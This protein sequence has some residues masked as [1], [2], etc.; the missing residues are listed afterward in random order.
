M[1][2]RIAERHPFWSTVFAFVVV[3]FPEWLSSVW[4]LFKS[5]PLAM[6]VHR[7]F[8]A[9][10]LPQ[11]SPYFI[12]IPIGL[13]MFSFIVYCIIRQR[14]F[15]FDYAY[16]LAIKD[17]IY[18]VDDLENPTSISINLLLQNTAHGPLKYNIDQLDIIIDGH[19]HTNPVFDNKGGVIPRGSEAKFLYPSFNVGLFAGK[20]LLDG[21]VR[22]AISY[23]HPEVGMVRLLKKELSLKLKIGR[24]AGIT[25]IVKQESD[26]E[27]KM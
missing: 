2:R 5:E 16:G 9:M 14:K 17:F 11:F 1:L 25:F 6:V 19:T 27:I 8:I 12:T 24:N 20:L 3:S 21:V 18:G 26:V 22:V 15:S 23:G 10:N 7:R 4:G 13:V